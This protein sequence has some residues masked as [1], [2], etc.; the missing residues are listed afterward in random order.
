MFVTNSGTKKNVKKSKTCIFRWSQQIISDYCEKL[1]CDI[2]VQFVLFN[3]WN[4]SRSE[5]IDFCCP[6]TGCRKTEGLLCGTA[7]RCTHTVH[8][9]P[10]FVQPL[11]PALPS[12]I[13]HNPQYCV[14]KCP[15]LTYSILVR[16]LELFYSHELK[17]ITDLL[18]LTS[19]LDFRARWQKY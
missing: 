9:F 19:R 5:T 1:M 17:N 3:I 18:V 6:C 8:P 13:A 10:H 7:L 12:L 4:S 2:V 16:I 11:S 15:L 14:S